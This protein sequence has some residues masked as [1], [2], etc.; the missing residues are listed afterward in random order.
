VKRNF[1]KQSTKKKPNLYGNS[2]F[3]FFGAKDHFKKYDV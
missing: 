1:E 3:F 2:N